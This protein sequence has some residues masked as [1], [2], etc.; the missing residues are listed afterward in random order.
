MILFFP[1]KGVFDLNAL[2]DFKHI[3]FD[4]IDRVTCSIHNSN[5]LKALSD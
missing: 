3:L 5:P 1:E 2:E 4:S